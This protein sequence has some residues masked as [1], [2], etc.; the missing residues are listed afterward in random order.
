MDFVSG[1][2]S[3]DGNGS[4]APAVNL[5]ANVVHSSISSAPIV[6]IAAKN[7]MQ[8]VQHD[9]KS[10]M[11]NPNAR[12]VLA[13]AEGPA[14]PFRFN[15]APAGAKQAGM[16]S[17]EATAIEDWTFN[18]QY[19]TYQRSG[20]AMDSSS[21]VVL[22]DYEAYLEANGDTAQSVRGIVYTHT[23]LLIIVIYLID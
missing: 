15:V 11:N 3:D 13:A 17:I 22:G 2:D 1:Y 16:G 8:M 19:Q 23:T 20:F 10:L 7:T 5:V 21:N 14:H 18:E 12:V 6:A 4:A 9:Q